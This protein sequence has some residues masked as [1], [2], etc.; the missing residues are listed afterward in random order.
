MGLHT[1]LAD[2][3]IPPR[4]SSCIVLT[5]DTTARAYDLRTLLLGRLAAPSTTS[6]NPDRVYLAITA[7][8]A[9]CYLQFDSTNTVTLDKTAAIAAGSALAETN[10]FGDIIP[11]GVLR[12]FELQ[13]AKDMYLHVQGSAAGYIHISVSS[14]PYPGLR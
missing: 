5:L 3:V 8:T 13:R 12:S 10:T 1:D 9:D 7:R 6:P 4:K 14:E 11:A 2:N